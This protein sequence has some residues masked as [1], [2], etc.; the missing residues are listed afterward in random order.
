MTEA[1]VNLQTDLNDYLDHSQTNSNTAIQNMSNAKNKQETIQLFKTFMR[2]KRFTPLQ[3]AYTNSYSSAP[4]PQNIQ[5]IHPLLQLIT[6]PQWWVSGKL[7][8]SGGSSVSFMNKDFL[9][10]ICPFISKSSLEQRKNLLLKREESKHIRE[11]T[12]AH[13][14][15]NKDISPSN[16]S[17]DNNTANYLAKKNIHII[18]KYLTI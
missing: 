5:V 1:V 18:K 11:I 16:I 15:N 12:L 7:I 4:T 3:K 14:P 10:V 2:N 8:P 13:C 6:F 9:S 17:S